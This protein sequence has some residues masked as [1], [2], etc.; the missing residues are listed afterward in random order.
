MLERLCVG[1]GLVLLLKVNAEAV[2]PMVVL[3]AV[4]TFVA[5]KRPYKKQYHNVRQIANMGIAIIVE[6]VY[7]AFKLTDNGVHNT[8][9]LFFYLPLI[10]CGL[11]VV[12]VGYKGA[13]IGY[14]IFKLIKSVKGDPSSTEKEEMKFLEQQRKGTADPFNFLPFQRNNMNET[15]SQLNNLASPTHLSQLRKGLKANLFTFS[16]PNSGP[17]ELGGSILQDSFELIS[18]SKPANNILNT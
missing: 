7:L 1:M 5:L 3:V 2:I 9:Q 10:I 11:L 16:K 6:C 15:S 12:C 14:S 4:A 13:A 18:E 8:S 17:S